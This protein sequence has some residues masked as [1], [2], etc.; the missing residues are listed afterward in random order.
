ML[1]HPDNDPYE[2]ISD[3]F[4]PSCSTSWQQQRYVGGQPQRSA[5]TFQQALVNR[6]PNL[7]CLPAFILRHDSIPDAVGLYAPLAAPLPVC[8]DHRG[9]CH[10]T[11]SGT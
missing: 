4:D 7:Q 10:R 11:S 6:V 9:G 8:S 5:L 3:A 2:C 1:T